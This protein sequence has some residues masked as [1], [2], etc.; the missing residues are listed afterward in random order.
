MF[1]KILDFL[2]TDYNLAYLAGAVVIVGIILTLIIMMIKKNSKQAKDLVKQ[3]EDE[4][5]L[6]E[7]KDLLNHYED[8]DQYLYY[9]MPD[10]DEYEESKKKKAPEE[11]NT[12]VPVTGILV[13]LK[14]IAS[15]ERP[16]KEVVLEKHEKHE[17]SFDD[18][19]EFDDYILNCDGTILIYPDS[20]GKHRARYI[21]PTGQPIA[22]TY[23]VYDRHLLDKIINSI[24]SIAPFAT[25][26]D[27]TDISDFQHVVKPEYLIYEDAD[28]KI[29]FKLIAANLDILLVSKGYSSKEACINGIKSLINVAVKH[30][31]KEAHAN[32][33]L[34]AV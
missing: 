4:F 14:P 12:Q 11:E 28:S 26:T 15:K 5:L 19:D 16:V 22:H 6:L 13:E 9:D 3:E 25:L 32:R 27:L 1:E 31:T 18:L 21:S 17:Y 34:V 23:D 33:F 30:K 2:L 20:Y 7:E 10:F 8:G 29:R 24:N